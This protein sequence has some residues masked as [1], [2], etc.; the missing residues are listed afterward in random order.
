M[1][2][3]TQSGPPS[4]RNSIPLI[5]GATVLVMAI[6]LAIGLSSGGSDAPAASD[7]QSVLTKVGALPASVYESVGIGS[8][9][10]PPTKISAPALQANG[11]PRIV[12]LGAEYCPCCGAERWAMVIALSRFGS[13]SK[14]SLSHSASADVFPDTQT[15]SFHGSRYTS[16]LISFTGLESESNQ[17]KDGA[18][19]PLDSIPPDLLKLATD[20]AAGAIPFVDFGG[21]YVLSGATYDPGVLQ[22]KTA[23][24]IATELSDPSSEVAKGAVGSANVLTAAICAATDQK[25][26]QVCATPVI[27]RVSTKLAAGNL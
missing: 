9:S 12:Y 5:V 22:G 23:D 24:Q 8:A 19:A 20:S 6:A 17:P 2:S 18:Y 11:K 21:K 13:F 25:P 4:R 26:A 10:N 7:K 16:D 3:P 15:F 14:I 27:Q 1:S